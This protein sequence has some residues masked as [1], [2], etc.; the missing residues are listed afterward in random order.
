MTEAKKISNRT[1]LNQLLT[2]FP[3][4]I[5]PENL[6]INGENDDLMKFTQNV[7][8]IKNAPHLY[9]TQGISPNNANVKKE[10]HTPLPLPFVIQMRF[11]KYEENKREDNGDDGGEAHAFELNRPYGNRR[12]RQ[13]GDHRDRR[14]N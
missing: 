5:T 3:N 7:Y 1:F 14:Q 11:F 2:V 10:K 13:T 6:E 12:A 4:R 8:C 9:L